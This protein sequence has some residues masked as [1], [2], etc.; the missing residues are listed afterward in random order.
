MFMN[1][2]KKQEIENRIENSSPLDSASIL[3]SIEQY[4]KEEKAVI[5]E[6]YSQFE[7]TDDMEEHL[8]VPIFT[9]IIDGFLEATPATRKLRKKGLTATRLVSEC[10]TFSYSTSDAVYSITDGYVEYKNIGEATKKDFQAYGNGERPQYEG[11]RDLW[12]DPN[13]LKTYK[14]NIFDNNGGTINAEDEYTGKKNIYKEQAHPDAR[15]NIAKYKHTHQAHV[16]HIEPL[17][18]IHARLKGNYALS[19]EDIK[20]IANGDYNLALTAAYINN[21]TG[22]QGKGN[23]GDNT[24][25]EFVKNQ[26][27]RK[28][29]GEPNLGLSKKAKENIL[30]KEKEANAAIDKEINKKVAKNIIGTGD[31]AQQQVILEKSAQNALNQSK[32]YM[33]G[34]V[35]LF[36]IKPLYYEI[37]DTFRNGFKE[38]VNAQSVSDALSMRFCRVKRYVLDNALHFLGNSVWNFVKDFISSLIEGFISLFVG[39]FKQILKLV[40]EGIRIF[41]QAGTVLWGKESK[42]MTATQKGDAIIKILGS[43]VIAICGI[44]IEAL[45]NK[46]G[47]GEPWSIVLSTMLSGIASALFMFTLDKLDLFNVNADKRQAR[48]DDIY[49]ERI[50]EME[51][52]TTSMT[53]ELMERNRKQEKEFKSLVSQYVELSRQ[54]DNLALL[55]KQIEIANFLKVEL[56]YSDLEEF[57]KMRQ[58]EKL[59]WRL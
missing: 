48:L 43:S 5:D 1:N 53:R 29:E 3:L 40:K 25:T 44:G 2:Q 21:G 13:K 30:Q 18:R 59:K 9:S 35:M 16:D 41:T 33:V 52:T 12:E 51:E 42:Q 14:N 20:N 7:S 24:G 54:E 22:A 34:N 36:L 10:R 27:R 6:L 38:G 50:K 32:E 26:E 58:E 8:L 37:A 11:Q 56:P 17:S 45:L 46:I 23:K 49:N 28:R 55:K 15:R 19:D 31:G 57:K 39:I 4:R 47:I